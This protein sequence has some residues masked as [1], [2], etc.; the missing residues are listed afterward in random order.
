MNAGA[1]DPAQEK[2]LRALHEL[3][4]TMVRTNESIFS[5]PSFETALKTSATS[6][7]A[8]SRTGKHAP[9]PPVTAAESAVIPTSVPLP[10]IDPAILEI[11]KTPPI[12][13]RSTQTAA[14]PSTSPTALESSIPPPPVHGQGP[15]IWAVLAILSGIV[16]T[17]LS[18]RSLEKGPRMLLRQLEPFS[19]DHKGPSRSAAPIQ[20][21]GG[22]MGQVADRLNR[23]L[24]SARDQSA[25]Q[26]SGMADIRPLLKGLS[27]RFKEIKDRHGILSEQASR[28]VGAT[29]A[30]GKQ[31]GAVLAALE[32]TSG[33]MT[34]VGHSADTL[35]EMLGRSSSAM[36]TSN[37]NLAS[38]A[39]AAAQASAGLSQISDLAQRSNSNISSTAAAV[40]S[41]RA[42]LDEVRS[43]CR[44][45]NEQ[46]QL[47]NNLA[48]DNRQVM[49]Q[50]SVSAT[51]I[52]SMVSMINDIA[53]QTNMLALNAAI[54]AAGAGDAGKGFA[55]VANEVKELAR[56]TAHATQLI[57]DKATDIQTNTQEMQSRGEKVSD[58][59]VRINRSNN[60]ILVAMDV[61][62][63]TMSTV[64]DTMAEI[65][66]E[67][68]NVTRQVVE[69]IHGITEITR[70]VH[71]VSTS[72]SD[73]TASVRESSVGFH[74]MARQVDQ[75]EQE[76]VEVKKLVQVERDQVDHE[77]TLLKELHESIVVL[78]GLGDA[79]DKDILK[80][81]AA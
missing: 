76:C 40:E 18:V 37:H 52:Q 34:G 73:V 35:I 61:Q 47:A 5:D 27:S 8:L 57:S 28:A 49:E 15:L 4:R 12:V 51:E 46:S 44:L 60:E 62:G 36:E 50:L 66:E 30:L 22:V 65:A 20:L 14:R 81:G 6:T 17:W 78:D 72:L 16:L 80:I 23:C 26:E 3:A 59:I 70:N 31:H 77:T 55:V 24:Q 79:L 71:E 29:D 38:V 53:E 39:A 42:S 11:P 33:L 2:G 45:A 74:E 68:N 56:Q 32:K 48:N 25:P 69:S 21:E 7:A 10:K 63:D 43:L 75:A 9:P 58:S 13:S 67:T 41:F 19:S 64:A 1:S 54:E